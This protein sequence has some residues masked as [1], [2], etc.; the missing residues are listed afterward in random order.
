MMHNY[1][2]CTIFGACEHAKKVGQEKCVLAR[3][4]KQPKCPSIEEWIK[5]MWCMYVCI[6]IYTHTHTME[7]YS[8]IKKMK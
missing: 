3:T 5:N 7:Y 2:I 1:L 6:Y 4:W 8:V